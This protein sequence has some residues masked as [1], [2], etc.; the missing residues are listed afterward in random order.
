M[1]QVALKLQAFLLKLKA[2]VRDP[3]GAGMHAT[4]ALAAFVV[5]PAVVSA[6][7]RAEIALNPAVLLLALPMN[8]TTSLLA[9]M[10]ES[11]VML[12]SAAMAQTGKCEQLGIV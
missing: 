4:L 3:P 8:G 2:E 12:V 10:A 7:A 1:F 5:T 6:I 9:T 11:T